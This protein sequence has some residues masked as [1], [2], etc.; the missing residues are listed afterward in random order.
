MQNTSPNFLTQSRGSKRVPGESPH[1]ERVLEVHQVWDDLVL[2]TKHFASTTGEITIGSM[3]GWRWSVLGVQLGWL[4]SG[5][6]LVARYAPPLWSEVESD[7]KNDFYAPDDPLPL[8]REHTLFR[9]RGA[10]WEA[11]LDES[12]TATADLDGEQLDLEQ[13]SDRGLARRT[14][15]GWTVPITGSLALTITIGSMSFIAHRVRQ[16]ERTVA[17]VGRDWPFVGITS[18]TAFV[19]AMFAVL[20][21]SQPPPSEVEV[22]RVPDRIVQMVLEKPEKPEKKIIDRGNK[23]A[24]EGKSAPD[25]RGKVGKRNAEKKHAKGKP[26]TLSKRKRDMDVVNAAGVLGFLTNNG[27]QG[28]AFDGGLNRNLTDAIGGLSGPKGTQIGTGGFHST[29]NGTGNNGVAEGTGIGTHGDGYGATGKCEPGQVCGPGHRGTGKEYGAIAEV[30]GD[31]IIL[32]SL[33]RAL[34]DEVVK[35]HMSQIRYCYQREL[36][37]DASVGGKLVIRWTIANDGSVSRAGTK[38]STIDHAGVEQCVEGRF[39]RMTFPKPRGN[40]IVIVT[41]PFLFNPGT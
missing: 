30:K 4:P 8:G 36:Q 14:D 34:I 24:A 7:W 16:A 40:G 20:I 37:K 9:W 27:P 23:D 38:S 13:L 25:E 41:Y 39:L 26:G 29:G 17:P 35:R 33:D 12:W 11:D 19:G 22:S 28:G 5:A 15:D 10:Q 18:A 1:R 3:V 31:P 2:D 32:G 6:H 21:W